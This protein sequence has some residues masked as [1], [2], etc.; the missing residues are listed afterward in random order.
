M[1][2]CVDDM[3]G[4]DRREWPIRCVLRCLKTAAVSNHVCAVSL[5]LLLAASADDMWTFTA[6][7]S[8]WQMAMYMFACH[9]YCMYQETARR[10]S[11]AV[12]LCMSR[13]ACP[14]CIMRHHASLCDPPPP[15]AQSCPCELQQT[16]TG[17]G[18]KLTS[19]NLSLNAACASVEAKAAVISV[20]LEP[21]L[22]I[23][24]VRVDLSC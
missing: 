15:P 18:T 21:S 7:P 2:S 22:L 20:A 23:D 16:R 6:E 11:W 14:W 9:S 4:V 24:A 19:L 8:A 10:Q 12:R 13:T 1:N 17:Q 5:P 3:L